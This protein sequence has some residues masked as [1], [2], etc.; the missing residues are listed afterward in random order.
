MKK[1]MFKIE[2]VAKLIE[3]DKVL[4]L[5]GDENLLKKLPKG[6]WIGGTIPYFM[7]EKGGM[8][9]KDMILVNEMPDFIKSIKCQAYDATNVH[10]IYND[11]F[12]NGFTVIIVPGMSDL[13]LS[14][15]N[16][17]T[18]FDGFATKPL[19]GW[20]SGGLLADL[21]QRAPGTAFGP[22]ATFSNDR[23]VAM[24]IELP[25][26]K[27]AQTSIINIF[28]QGNGDQIEFPKSGFTA[29]EV[30]INGQKRNF[31]DYIAEKK[32]DIR[33]P[34]VADYSGSMINISFQHVDQAK[35]VVS[36]YAP[37][38]EGVVYKQAG[39]IENYIHKFSK[40]V[41]S[42]GKQNL[43]FS[44]NCILNF[45][46]SELEGKKTGSITGPFTFG[47]IAYQLLNQTMVNLEIADLS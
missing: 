36:F 30:L 11:G 14:F 35:K 9:T 42:N 37:V 32:L 6:N 41:P 29:T 12:E 3:K 26:G 15:A 1:T 18:D 19:V 46:Y 28:S 20:I 47:E 34:L 22:E 43:T 45:L 5:A 44:C 31:A 24:H 40:Q 38:F 33:L 16:N 39:K 4:L 8:V 21:N 2:E 27:Y 10:A 25:K 7:S 13:H 23:A 17:A